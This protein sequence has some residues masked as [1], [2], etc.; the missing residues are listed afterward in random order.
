[1]TN[2]TSRVS[3]II[4]VYNGARFLGAALASVQQ[5]SHQPLEIIVID[6][7]STDNTAKIIQ[8]YNNKKHIDIPIYGINIEK[9]PSMQNRF[10]IRSIPTII[11]LK[12]EKIITKKIGTFNDLKSF[13]NFITK[14]ID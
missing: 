1:M 8:E 10:H 2:K 3:V 12:N 13:E 7:G 6:D 4:P 9:I 14:N 11:I 5:Q